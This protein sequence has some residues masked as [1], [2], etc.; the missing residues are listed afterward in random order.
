MIGLEIKHD[1]TN[2]IVDN[3][4]EIQ[5]GEPATAYYATLDNGGVSLKKA[6]RTKGML[7][8]EKEKGAP[9]SFFQ[10]AK[11]AQDLITTLIILKKNTV[12]HRDIIIN[13][14]LVYDLH[15]EDKENPGPR[16]E[17]IDFGWAK[18]IVNGTDTVGV[19]TAKGKIAPE[20]SLKSKQYDSLIASKPY[21]HPVDIFAT[22]HLL[23]EIQGGG[24]KGNR[25]MLCSG[26]IY[27]LFLQTNK[28]L[29]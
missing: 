3:W 17:L 5:N 1:L 9:I 20:L 23:A 12:L 11:I 24:D 22:G 10:F 19:G 21:S 18:K 4:I 13:N 28:Y 27:Q 26:V 29:L 7:R 15:G 14:V 25:S 16:T 2:K 8:R 6:L